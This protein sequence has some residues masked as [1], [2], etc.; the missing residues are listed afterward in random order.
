M[1]SDIR[2]CSEA[3]SYLGTQ[4]FNFN[5]NPHYEIAQTA[6]ERSRSLIAEYV[7]PKSLFCLV[8]VQ[9]D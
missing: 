6:E 5:I 2:S 9:N 3:L 4:S 1:S 7:R 8:P